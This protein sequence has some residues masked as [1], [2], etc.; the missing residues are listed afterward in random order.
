MLASSQICITAKTSTL[1]SQTLTLPDAIT[2]FT[3]SSLWL[4]ATAEFSPTLEINSQ[5]VYRFQQTHVNVPM[6]P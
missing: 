2:A 3:L 5:E 4:E 1:V 6:L